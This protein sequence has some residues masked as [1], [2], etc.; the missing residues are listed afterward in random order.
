MIPL[1]EMFGY[2]TVLRSMTEGRGTFTME[3][4]SYVPVPS[5]VSAA[6][7]EARGK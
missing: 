1:A 5:N 4:S 7:I 3:P 2:A 6:I